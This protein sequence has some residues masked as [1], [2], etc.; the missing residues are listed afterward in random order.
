[1]NGGC[2][3]DGLSDFRGWLIG[4]GKKTYF[5]ALSNPETLEELNHEMGDD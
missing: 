1:M 3:D 4:E 2:G 5:K